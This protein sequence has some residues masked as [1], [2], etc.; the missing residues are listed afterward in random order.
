MKAAGVQTL[1]GTDNMAETSKRRRGDRR[2]GKLIRDIEP[3]QYF[4]GIIYPNRQRGLFYQDHR[5][6]QTQ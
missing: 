4:T 2:D 1:R 5:S 6:D 3:I